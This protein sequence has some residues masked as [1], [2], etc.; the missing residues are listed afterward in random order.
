[1]ESCMAYAKRVLETWREKVRA[2]YRQQRHDQKPKLEAD[3]S[4][5]LGSIISKAGTASSRADQKGVNHLR[6]VHVLQ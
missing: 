4:N 2:A 1:M 6:V 3:C 5:I